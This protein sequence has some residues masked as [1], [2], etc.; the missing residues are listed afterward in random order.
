MT[1]RLY[2][3]DAYLTQF[4]AHVV[5]RT[6]FQQRPAVV[7][8]RTAFYPTSGGQ[9]FDQGTLDGTKVVDVMVREAD[10]AVLHVLEA[11]LS[12][13]F[14][15]HQENEPLADAK[16]VLIQGKIDWERRFDHMQQHTGQHILSQAFIQTAQAQTVSFHLSGESVTI[17]LS[18]PQA[19]ST[20]DMD[21]TERLAN[22]IV[23][24][25]RP[26]SVRF[27]PP[28]ALDDVPLRKTPAV[29]GDVRVVKVADFDWSAC[30]GTHVGRTGEIGMIKIVKWERR[31]DETRVEFRCGRR[32]FCD[33]H[34]KNRMVNQ[35]AAG[36]NVGYWEL[37]Q[38]VDRLVVEIKE[39]RANLRKANQEL[40]H[41]E[42]AEM[43]G[44]APVIAGVRLIIQRLPEDTAIDIRWLAHALV[45]EPSVVTLLGIGT[46]EQSKAQF[47]FARSSDVEIDMVPLVR[48]AARTLG[49]PRGGGQPDFA[50]GGGPISDLQQIDA[51]LEQAAQ[52]V[53]QRLE[54]TRA[55]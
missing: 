6:T 17:D 7:L 23:W 54:G 12:A 28:S 21:R 24:Q 8:D 35:V 49:A 29:S 13:S 43:R 9:P 30:G 51:A 39:L 50:Q 45:S 18:A 37:D 46:L 3:H 52:A 31:G 47:Y 42:A 53:I 40:T 48:D 27:V 14:T 55:K 15:D 2:Y 34:D 5:E 10:E 25:D 19:L 33:Y 4:T 44:A 1:E 26:V 16:V 38:A 22:E 36:F 20:A 11:P 41:Y 32:A